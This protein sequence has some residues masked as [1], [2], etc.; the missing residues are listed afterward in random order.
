[1]SAA[2]RSCRAAFAHAIHELTAEPTEENVV[3]YLMASRELEQAA[4]AARE[5]LRRPRRARRRVRL[6]AESVS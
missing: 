5:A 6:S 3:R 4:V 2:S 1:M